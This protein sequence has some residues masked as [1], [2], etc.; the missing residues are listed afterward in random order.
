MA[1]MKAKIQILRKGQRCRKGW[2]AV[3]IKIGKTTRRACIRGKVTKPPS[4]ISRVL[5]GAF[6]ALTPLTWYVH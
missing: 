4:T 5:D 1:R 6:L 2:T 3:E